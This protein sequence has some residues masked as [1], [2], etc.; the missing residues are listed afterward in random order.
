MLTEKLEYVIE[1]YW[2]Q[3]DDI[4]QQAQWYGLAHY[5]MRE[6]DDC[7]SHG[8]RFEWFRDD[9]GFILVGTR[10]DNPAGP[11]NGNFFDVTYAINYMPTENFVL[12]PEIR[13]DWYEPSVS[14]GPQPFDDGTRSNQ[15]LVSIDAI[16]TF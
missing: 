4:N 15:F 14:G 13:W 7:W 8:L 16:W 11:F 10:E 1:W 6:I 2:G 5:L 9:D 3:S 12:R